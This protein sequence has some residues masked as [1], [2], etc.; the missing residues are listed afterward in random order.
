GFYNLSCMLWPCPGSIIL[1]FYLRS[2][3]G[4][5]ILVGIL[6]T[7]KVLSSA[8][9]VVSLIHITHWFYQLTVYLYLMRGNSGL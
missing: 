9:S 1:A 6:R 5:V 3:P 2:C 7:C 4:S 8:L